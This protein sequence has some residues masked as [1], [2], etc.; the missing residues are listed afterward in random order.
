MPCEL[1]LS[2]VVINWSSVEFLRK[3]LASVFANT[4]RLKFEA[5]VV[6]NAS[7]DGCGEMVESEF[8]GVIFIQ[9]HQ[10]LGFSGAN[11]LGFTRSK[12]RNILFLNPDTE[13]IG[14]AVEAMSLWLDSQGDAGAVGVKLLNSDLS[15]QTSCIQA[16]PTILNEA[17][18]SERLREL[19]PKA[20]LWGTRPLFAT[21]ATPE[22]VEVISGA[23]LMAKRSVLEKVGGI[24][25]RLFH[26]RRRCGPLLQNS[27]GRLEVLLPSSGARRAPRRSKF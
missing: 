16:F 9:S 15:L 14:P 13:V 27:T 20:A 26:V 7:F 24:Q 18:D 25:Q 10:N 22:A 21:S 5:I 3:C 12:G 17:L 6:D 1:D 19:F 2:I 11:N 23:C 4:P 8:P